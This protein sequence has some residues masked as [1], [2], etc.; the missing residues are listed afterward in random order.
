MK[1][2]VDLWKRTGPLLDEL[3]DEDIRN[4]DTQNAVEALSDAFDSALRHFSPRTTSGLVEMQRI[5]S[6]IK[7]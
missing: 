4:A 2:W 6:R 1:Q 3:R 5:F 7:K